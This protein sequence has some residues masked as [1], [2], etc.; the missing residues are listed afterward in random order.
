[1]L[2]NYICDRGCFKTR[3][4]G[5]MYDRCIT[6]TNN[7]VPWCPTGTDI[8]TKE[9]TAGIYSLRGIVFII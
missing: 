6:H 9:M 1:M 8:L 3:F 5:R 7:A 4:K 2:L